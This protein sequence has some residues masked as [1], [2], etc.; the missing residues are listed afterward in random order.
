MWSWPSVSEWAETLI[1]ITGESSLLLLRVNSFLLH[2]AC[3]V[4]MVSSLWVCQWME[5][6]HG[7]LGVFPTFPLLGLNVPHAGRL[8][9]PWALTETYRRSDSM[10]CFKL[11]AADWPIDSMSSDV[12]FFSVSSRIFW[13]DRLRSSSLWGSEIQRWYWGWDQKSSLN[14]GQKHVKVGQVSIQINNTDSQIV[15]NTMLVLWKLF[16]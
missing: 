8:S 9:P 16:L 14:L 13:T 11:R 15:L 10:S 5:R 3:L 4:F 2:S 1:P 6:P 7:M 12:T